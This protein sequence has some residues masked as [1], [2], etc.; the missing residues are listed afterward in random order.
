MT[1]GNKTTLKITGTKQKYK[2]QSNATS[3]A[4]VNSKGV[5]TAKKA[6]S[7]I[8]YVKIGCKYLSCNLTVKKIDFKKNMTYEEIKI[9]NGIMYKFTNKNKVAV[10]IDISNQLVFF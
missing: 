10:K 5:V 3:V 7:A 9:P 1:V 2:W 4:T 8:I 6:G